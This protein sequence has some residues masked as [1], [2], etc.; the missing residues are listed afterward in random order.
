MSDKLDIHEKYRKGYGSPFDRGG[1]DSYYH[2]PR[3][4]HKIVS[5]TEEVTGRQFFKEI[6]DLTPEEV[7]AYNAGYEDN[8]ENGD[9]K[10][11]G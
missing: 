11:W 1:A 7:E 3:N 9:K 5:E 4:P 2:R 6:I 10:D 8:E